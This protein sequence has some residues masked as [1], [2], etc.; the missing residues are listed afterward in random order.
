MCDFANFKRTEFDPAAN[1]SVDRPAV[2]CLLLSLLLSLLL[3]FHLVSLLL[4]LCLS[5]ACFPMPFISESEFTSYTYALKAFDVIFLLSCALVFR[6]RSRAIL[7]SGFAN[8]NFSLATILTGGRRVFILIGYALF[9]SLF[10]IFTAQVFLPSL[11]FASASYR[12][13]VAL[14]AVLFYAFGWPSV[15]AAVFCLLLAVV[16][17]LLRASSAPSVAEERVTTFHRFFRAVSFV[18]GTLC[19]LTAAVI[20]LACR[21]DTFYLW[22]PNLSNSTSSPLAAR[23]FFLIVTYA[24]PALSVISD[25]VSV[26]V[27]S[28]V[29][30]IARLG[31]GLRARRTLNSPQP[32]LRP[33]LSSSPAQSPVAP[34][35]APKQQHTVE[36]RIIAF[37]IA[38]AV[39]SGLLA[40]TTTIVQF[41]EAFGAHQPSYD[42]KTLHNLFVSVYRATAELLFLAML[43][44]TPKRRTEDNPL[45]QSPRTW[46]PDAPIAPAGQAFNSL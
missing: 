13:L 32:E 24:I 12:R 30:R 14:N 17:V 9:S 7:S 26:A 29:L 43:P 28:A 11:S 21:E 19:A 35:R 1:W 38:N 10:N 16:S 2:P 18:L 40:V 41:S 20:L 23:A 44:A 46:P 42:I 37:A 31:R 4:R 36:T 34:R 3:G 22:Y 39:I 8:R 6:I 33:P 27:L 25:A 15:V 5:L 45:A